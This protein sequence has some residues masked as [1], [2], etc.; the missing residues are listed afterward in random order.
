MKK[1]AVQYACYLVGYIL[2]ECTWSPFYFQFKV[3]IYFILNCSN[4]IFLLFSCLLSLKNFKFQNKLFPFL[5]CSLRTIQIS[6]YLIVPAI[7]FNTFRSDQVCFSTIY[8]YFYLCI[9]AFHL[10]QMVANIIYINAVFFFVSRLH[11]AFLKL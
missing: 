3:L 6:L 8:I 7:S 5:L 4:N 11:F 1:P 10:L 2:Q 9:C